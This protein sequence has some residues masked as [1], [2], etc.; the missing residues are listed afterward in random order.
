M[1]WLQV[2]VQFRLIRRGLVT[3][4][5]RNRL[6]KMWENLRGKQNEPE[7]VIAGE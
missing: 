3:E 2:A 6:W 4:E 1:A 7:A 5:L